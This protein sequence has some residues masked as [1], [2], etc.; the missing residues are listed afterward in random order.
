MS[1]VRAFLERNG[2]NHAPGRPIAGRMSRRIVEKAARG[3]WIRPRGRLRRSLRQRRQFF[4]SNHRTIFHVVSVGDVESGEVGANLNSMNI[5]VLE[6]PLEVGLLLISIAAIGLSI[7]AHPG[8]SLPSVKRISIG[9]SWHVTLAIVVVFANATHAR[10]RRT[11]RRM[12]ASGP[13][14]FD[15]WR[16]PDRLGRRRA[17][18]RCCRDVGR[19]APSP[20][21]RSGANS[22]SGTSA[23][24]VPVP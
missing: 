17:R 16:I 3:G 22:G 6:R 20:P 21:A 1:F 18:S 14:P 10:P 12:L 2:L 19:P 9:A 8:G 5:P 4:T 11:C 24:S 23:A 15:R 7:V 13:G